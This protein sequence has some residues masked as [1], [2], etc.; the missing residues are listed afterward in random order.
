MARS[1][2]YSGK[3]ENMCM[4]PQYFAIVQLQYSLYRLFLTL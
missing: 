3:W 2:V 1:E 4:N